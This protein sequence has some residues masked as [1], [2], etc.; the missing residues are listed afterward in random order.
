MCGTVTSLSDRVVRDFF[1]EIPSKYEGVDGWV[2]EMVT[3]RQQR[4]HG[5]SIA[6][7]FPVLKGF[8]LFPPC[9]LADLPQLSS[10]QFSTDRLH[11]RFREDM[12]HLRRF[13]FGEEAEAEL[14]LA[15]EG[16]EM[17]SGP[18]PEG[19]P[20]E[21]TPTE[22]ESDS[23]TTALRGEPAH[24]LFTGGQFAALL[25]LLVTLS[26][27][28]AFPELPAVWERFIESQMEAAVVDAV[29]VVTDALRGRHTA[30]DGQALSDLVVT[31]RQ[32]AHQHLRHLLAGFPQALDTA[33][34]RFEAE[35]EE[36]T[37]VFQAQNQG[38]LEGEVR[39]VVA[40]LREAFATQLEQHE[41]S[42][43]LLTLQAAHQS[44][45][46]PRDC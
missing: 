40:D 27:K 18:D 21:T 32:R 26:N 15:G 22:R 12:A 41:V 39:R 14:E 16:R 44:D 17:P 33:A 43:P 29:Q 7:V 46:S 1:Q 42:L 5:H 2:K 34:A 35:L 4:D 45:T 30:L 25:E 24:R 8:T 11:P 36:Q 9:E 3:N 38:R 20:N 28:D 6:Q 37:A 23:P 19:G 31:A 10:S 13:V